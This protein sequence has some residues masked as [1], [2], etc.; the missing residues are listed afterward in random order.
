MFLGI[1]PACAQNFADW[2]PETE[3]AKT[4]PAPDTPVNR[5]AMITEKNVE[6]LS[7]DE[8][9]MLSETQPTI[10]NPAIDRKYT[11]GPTDV[12]EIT[13]LRHPEVSGEYDINKAGYIQYEFVGDIQISGLEK[14]E[15]E[16]VIAE[17]LSEFIVSPEVTIK[18]TE[19]NSKIV[20]VVGEVF[21]PGKIYMRGDTITVREALMQAGLPRLSG[22]TKK[23]R[24][25]TPSENGKPERENINV[26]ALLYEGDLRQNE[27]MKPG[28]VL[29]IP[30]TFLTKT[31]RAISPITAP[32]GQAAGAR[33]G[34]DRLGAPQTQY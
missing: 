25:I 22:V 33:V 32:I 4:E 20:Y 28:D 12:I 17:H 18:I 23:S 13:V 10:E 6:E 34:V 19:Y 27:I 29:Y 9:R 2:T 5:D 11:L 21:R 15:A 3:P 30:A 1:S 26:Y 7:L 8:I 31:M 14:K 24:L 16:N